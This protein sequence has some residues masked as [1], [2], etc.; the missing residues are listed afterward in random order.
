M[1]ASRS[2]WEFRTLTMHLNNKF[3]AL[4][5]GHVACKVSPGHF[6]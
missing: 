1:P 3:K 6:S 2:L 4:V 5:G